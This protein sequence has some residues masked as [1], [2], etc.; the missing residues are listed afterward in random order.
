MGSLKAQCE[1]LTSSEGLG[2]HLV[3]RRPKDRKRV[4][5][6]GIGA[7]PLVPLSQLLPVTQIGQSVSKERPW[8]GGFPSLV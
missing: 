2:E 7:A 3:S 1:L 8:G 4:E 6:G 5:K